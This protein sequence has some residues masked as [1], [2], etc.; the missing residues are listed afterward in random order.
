MCSSASRRARTA[1]TAGRGAAW[2]G[3]TRRLSNDQLLEVLTG[4]YRAHGYLTRQLI[5]AAEGIPSA[6]TYSQ[7][8]RKPGGGL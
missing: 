6:G 8:L 7:A 5:N 1:A 3:T 4:L 2:P